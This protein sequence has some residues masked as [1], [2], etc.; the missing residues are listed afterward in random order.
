MNGNCFIDNC[1][2]EAKYNHPE[3]LI[4]PMHYQRWKKQI[5]MEN[6]IMHTPRIGICFTFNCENKIK[7]RGLCRTCYEYIFVRKSEPII[8]RRKGSY[9]KKKM[10]T[11]QGYVR[12]HDPK[13]P[14]ANSA[15]KVMEHRH[16][17]GEFI[18]R[19]LL[20]NEN[21]HHKNGNRS[22]N[23]IENLELWS[24]AQPPGQRIEDKVMWAREIIKLYGNIV[25]GKRFSA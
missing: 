3:G 17:M 5:P 23:R 2:K 22:D 7:A 18:G 20:S 21:V 14:H 6:A 4:C 13:S 15:G 8:Y 12:W 19:P 1:T 9:E 11:K 16:V 24:T 25:D 10:I